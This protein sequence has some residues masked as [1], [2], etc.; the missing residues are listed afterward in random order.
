MIIY[1]MAIVGSGIGGSLFASQYKNKNIIVFEKDTNLGGC[2]QT[3][4]HQGYS[5]NGGATTFAGYEDKHIVK[6]LFRHGNIEPNIKKMDIAFRV[7][8]GDTIIDRS[9]DFEQFLSSV[10]Q[11]YPNKNNRKFWTTIRSIDEKFWTIKDI[12]FAKHTIGNYIKTLKTS[13]TFF[14][15][16]GFD[17]FK[18]ADVFI[19]EQLGSISS[20]YRDFLE[21]TLM[22]TVQQKTQDLPL[23]FFA[24]GLSY[25]FH[26]LYYPIGGMGKIIESLLDGIDVHT[27]EGVTKIEKEDEIFLIHT[28]KSIYKAKKVILNSTLFDSQKIFVDKKIKRYY[29]QFMLYDQSAFVVYIKLKQKKEYLHHYQ[30]ILKES[31]PNCISNSYFISLSDKDDPIM[32][33]D[34]LSVTIST[35]TKVS[36]WKNLSKTDYDREKQKT[37][38]YIKNSFLEHLQLNEDAIEICFGATPNTYNRYINRSNCGG[39]SSSFST[40]LFNSGVAT[41]FK[42]LYQVGDTTM[43]AQGWPGVALG[44]DMLKRMI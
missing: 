43:G 11:A 1:E 15:K 41:P 33:K 28:K 19:K 30:I 7:I 4:K 21:A 36:F 37:L 10:E 34:G 31:I 9:S 8:Q 6:E 35:H 38:T 39:V 26:T 22:I 2:A 40:I 23:L 20:E 3:F 42:N 17:L 25:P 29:Q 14:S 12:Y 13:G 24:L 5:F 44:V 18:S 32:S 16:F 27:K